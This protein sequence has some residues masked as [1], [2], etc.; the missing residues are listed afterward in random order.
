[1]TLKSA[2]QEFRSQKIV[3]FEFLDS[4]LTKEHGLIIKKQIN[5]VK[6]K[7]VGLTWP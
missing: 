7:S 2:L 4:K 1:M 5:I 3:E 6:W